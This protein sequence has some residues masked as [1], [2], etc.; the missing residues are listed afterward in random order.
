MS[1]NAEKFNS[2]PATDLIATTADATEHFYASFLFQMNTG[3]RDLNL[4]FRNFDTGSQEGPRIDIEDSTNGTLAVV[5]PDGGTQHQIN[6]TFNEP[7]RIE[8]V[9]SMVPG[10]FSYQADLSNYTVAEDTFDIY[11][12]DIHG[13]LIG[14]A[15]GVPF[16]DKGADVVQKIDAIRAATVVDP[17][18]ILDDWEITTG[19]ISGNGYLKANSAS[20]TPSPSKQ[21]Y[22]MG[23]SDADQDGDGLTDW[24]ELQLAKHAPYLFFDAETNDGTNDLTSATALV[25][26]ATGSIEL[27]LQASDTAAYER[28]TPNLTEDH[29]E[30]IVTRTGPLTPVTVNLC[31]APLANTGNTATVCDGTC[32]TLVGS[33]GDE[34]AEANDYTLVDAYGNLITNTITFEF[35]EMSKTLTVIAT[36]DEINEYPETLNLA[37]ELDDADSYQISATNGA[38]IQLFDLPDHPDNVALFTGTFSQD[39]NAVT[40]TNGSGFTTATLNGPRTELLIWNEFSNLTSA[41]QDSHIHKANPGPAPGA[42]IYSITETPADETTDPLNG[43]LTEYPWDLTNS[44]GAVP[45]AGGAASKQ[46]IIDSLFNQN[47]ESPLYLN[48]HTVDNPAGEIWSFLNLSGGSQTDPGNPTVAASP[49]SAEYPQLSG[50]DLESEVRRFLNQATFGATDAQVSALVTTIENERLSDPSYHR[51]TAYNAWLDNQMNPTTTPQTY[52]LDYNLATDFQYYVLGGAFDPARNPGNGTYNT[53]TKP[54][55]WPTVDRSDPDPEKWHL[56][57]SYPITNNDL[58]LLDANNLNAEPYNRNRRQTHWQMMINAHDQLRQKAGFALQQIVVVSAENTGIRNNMYASANYQDM[59]NTHAFSHYR[60]VLGYVN[61]S[62][63]MGK[64]LSSLQ[65]QKAADLDGDGEFDIYPDENLA[66]ENMQLF[67]IGLFELW[68]DGTLRLGANGLPVPTY[69]NADIREFAKILT[70]QSFGKY[71][72]TNIGQWGGNAY[73]SIPEN[74]NFNTGQNVNGLLTMRYNYPMKMFGQY[75]DTTAKAFAGTTIDNTALT[76]P[77]AQGVADIEQAIDWLAGK[78]DDGQP[79][80]D[81]VNSHRSTPAFISRRLIQRFTTSNPSKNYLHRVAHTFK[82]NEGD[83][84][85]TIKAILL[86]PEARVPDLSNTTFGMKKSPLEAYI[87][88]LRSMEAFTHIPL[89]DP[90]GAPPYDTAPGN[91]TNPDLYLGNFGYPQLANHEKNH[92][93]LQDYTITAGT[94]DLQMIPFRQETVFNWYLPV[95]R[96]RWSHRQCRPRCA[97]TPTRQRTGH[98]AQH[99]LRRTTRPYHLWHLLG[100]P[101]QLYLQPTTC[102]LSHRQFHR[103][104]RPHPP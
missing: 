50:D 46:I 53:P 89:T 67:S 81:M 36:P 45:S 86:D 93:Y 77:N 76:D 52:L 96:P 101:R 34:A 99:Q 66:R 10:G 97:R 24:E 74:T 8:I 79:D 62:P 28:N 87:Q 3:H 38:S 47:G 2:D 94:E 49:G 75:H 71:N 102:L 4:Y 68:P 37:L 65:N 61:W 30:I 83:L 6:V 5:R 56:S 25:T 1:G 72:S 26:A 35:G 88:V 41:Q 84:A 40:S 64:W 57:L 27:T 73:A 14:S 95:L 103:Q 55:V 22:R 15:R 44:S 100:Q 82:E 104:Q 51:H 80:Y 16:R 85:L 12:S 69:T 17:N 32:C 59:L 33:A 39:G 91:F 13:N 70:G 29:G 42:I 9:A 19:S 21:F 18:I 54:A 31:Q 63:I 20:F 11:V 78:P 7:Y 60:D 48:I 23:I 98:H 58:R 92:R 90:V 43:P